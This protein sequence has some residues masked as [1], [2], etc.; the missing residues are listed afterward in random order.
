[1]ANVKVASN[2]NALNNI[3]RYLSSVKNKYLGPQ[4]PPLA[5][6]RSKK[7][8]SAPPHDQ[9]TYF[10]NSGPQAGSP[11]GLLTQISLSSAKITTCQN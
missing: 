11:Q 7:H 6:R 4:R 5:Q 1:M 8:H 3:A 2:A 9:L 10:D